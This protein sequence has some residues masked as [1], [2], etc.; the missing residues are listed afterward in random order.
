MEVIKHEIFFNEDVALFNA[1][2]G[3]FAI[4]ELLAYALKKEDKLTIE[5]K[6]NKGLA[7]QLREEIKSEPPQINKMNIEKSKEA[8]D[9]FTNLKNVRYVNSREYLQQHFDVQESDYQHTIPALY[10][11]Y[12]KPFRNTF[13]SLNA[14]I[15]TIYE[16]FHQDHIS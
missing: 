6:V 1:I 15:L 10:N 16:I 11:N 5:S 7:S 4:Y 13:A 2:K 9:N 3:F 14:G 8:K 12:V